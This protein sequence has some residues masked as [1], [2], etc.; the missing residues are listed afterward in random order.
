MPSNPEPRIL[1]HMSVLSESARCRV[2][3]L[4]ED[5]ELTVSDL[6][7]VLQLPQSTV[8]RHLKS[9]LDRG[10]VEVRPDRTRRLYHAAV[11]RL[12]PAGQNL[13]D[14][15]RE[16]LEQTPARRLDRARLRSVLAEQRSRS[17]E[18]FDESSDRW[19]TIRDE[20]YGHHFYLFGIAALVSPQSVVADLG[21]GTGT[22][23]EALAP[24]CRRV[25]GVDN[26]APML[27][28]ARLRLERFDN[29]EL[30]SGDIES[31][32]LDDGEADIVTLI[33]VLHHLEHPQSAIRE[34]ARCIAP[35]G[36]ILIVDMLPHDRAEY[37]QERGH[38]W[39][40][41]SQADI[42]ETLERAGFEV[43]RFHALPPAPEAK[44]P[45][46]F[47]VTAHLKETMA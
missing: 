32:P 4:L 19:D 31:L 21:C 36:R 33:L 1:D 45:N 8:S 2:L 16:E 9:L 35:G 3:L 46:L 41:F 20:L 12:D 25:I 37:R 27:E 47:A 22:V 6:C 28:L 10:W 17:Q 23:T 39:L 14:L 15:A 24:F 18:F 29:V 30:R 5:Q 38:V 43:E 7:A 44:G 40:G 42:R 26:S 13:W 11:D 34:A